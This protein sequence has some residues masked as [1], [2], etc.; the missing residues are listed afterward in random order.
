MLRQVRRVR[1]I[2]AANEPGE[3]ALRRLAP[4]LVLEVRG[5]RDH[6]V[7]TG[8][9][10]GVALG[11]RAH[12]QAAALHVL[13]TLLHAQELAHLLFGLLRIELLLLELE[14]GHAHDRA[15]R[16]GTEQAILLCTR[17]LHLLL[18]LAR[19]LAEHARL[20]G[21]VALKEE[22][23]EHELR[24]LFLVNDDADHID[25]LVGLGVLLGLGDLRGLEQLLERGQ[26]LRLLFGLLLL[27]R[28]RG[29]RGHDVE[30][31]IAEDAVAG[32][33]QRSDEVL[34]VLHL[35]LL[36]LCIRIGYSRGCHRHTRYERKRISSARIWFGSRYIAS[37]Q[38]TDSR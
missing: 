30:V 4:Q 23:A 2:A 6:Q 16:V 27:L 31:F 8:T 21:H 13:L 29:R 5:R 17:T 12:Q 35:H 19:L 26:L 18:V 1:V 20:V 15:Q 3:V 11:V 24:H 7:V 34:K 38:Y 37:R 36:R 32:V 33:G 14:L 10:V 9:L 25:L 22:L 28:R